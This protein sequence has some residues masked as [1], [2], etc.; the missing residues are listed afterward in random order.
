MMLLR[1]FPA[2]KQKNTMLRLSSG[3]LSDAMLVA[4]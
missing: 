2:Q 1:V 4:D 3:G